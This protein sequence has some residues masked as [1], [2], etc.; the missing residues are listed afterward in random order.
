M[1]LLSQLSPHIMDMSASEE[2]IAA[3]DEEM[4]EEYLETESL[5]DTSIAKKRF[6]IDIFIHSILVVQFKNQGVEETTDALDRYT[7]EK[8]PQKNYLHRSLRLREM[9]EENVLSLLR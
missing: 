1:T 2:D 8:E 6:L 4:I 5:K 9:K 7:L 3:L